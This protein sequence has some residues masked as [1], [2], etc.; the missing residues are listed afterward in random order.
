M[1]PNNE[2]RSYAYKEECNEVC[3][4]SCEDVSTKK[5]SVSKEILELNGS[6]EELASKIQELSIKI[7]P[8]LCSEN[9]LD[10]ETEKDCSAECEIGEEIRTYRRRIENISKIL[11]DLIDR[12][13]I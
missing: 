5:S 1:S 11:R 2:E 8:I 10:E 9:T 6:V 3:E 4:E 12:A 13:Q 7:K